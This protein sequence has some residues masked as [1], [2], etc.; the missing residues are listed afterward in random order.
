MRDAH[1][2]L[3]GL[4]N[5]DEPYTFYHD[6]TNNIK[7]L[8]VGAKGLNVAESAIFVLGGVVHAG[9]PRS[10]DI[11]SLRDAMR[12]QKSAD[13][14]KLKHVAKGEFL[15]LLKS[16]KLTTFLKWISDSSLVLHYH[17]LDP[18]YWSLVDIIDSILYRLGEPSLLEFHA[19]LKGRLSNA[20]A[21]QS[22]SHNGHIFPL[23]LS[24]PC[25]G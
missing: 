12:V 24:G 14:I 23:S 4:P 16:D 11:Q 1:I 7:K 21:H 6:E 22:S 18:L 13:E 3:Y 10:L 19:V 20:S 25:T 2:D 15:D 17:A 8:R 9:S 5:A